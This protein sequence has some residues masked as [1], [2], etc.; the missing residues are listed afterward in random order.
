MKTLMIGPLIFMT[1]DSGTTSKPIG[2][3]PSSRIKKI[4]SPPSCMLT[5]TISKRSVILC[6]HRVVAKAQRLGIYDLHGMYQEW[7]MELVAQVCATAW[8]RGN[9]YVQ[10]LNFS[11]EG[12]RFELRVTELPTIFALADNDFHRAEIITERT[13]SENEL[14]PLYFSGNEHN[15]GTTHGLL[16][17]YTIFN[18]I[19]RNTL[20]PK[21][22][23][24]INIQGSTRNLLLSI[25]DDQAP[26]CIGVF[27]WIEMWN[28]LTHGTQYVIYA[29]YI[30]MIINYKTD[31]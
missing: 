16:P 15:F 20:T 11:I 25:I 18:N 24:R 28:I 26:T 21:R 19:F 17:E 22:G 30:H 6:V 10:T 13:I 1:I 8:R 7:N 2:T 3:S 12:H 4:P 14:A 31:M 29:P 23:D 9:G 5:G 27:F